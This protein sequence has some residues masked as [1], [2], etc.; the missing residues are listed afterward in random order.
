MNGDNTKG[1]TLDYSE[2]LRV[3]LNVS[4]LSGHEAD[5]LG[6]I[7]DCIQVNLNNKNAG[8]DLLDSYTML[9]VEA[10]VSTRTT[11]MR[12]ISD[13]GEGGSWGFPDDTYSISYQSILGY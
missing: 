1:V 5:I 11:F 2:Y 8:I 9:A 13:L 7:A 10:K 12:K 4:L 6:R 3:F